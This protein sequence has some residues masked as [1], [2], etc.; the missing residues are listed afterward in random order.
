MMDITVHKNTA[1]TIAIQH[2]DASYGIFCFNNVGDLFVN[3]DWGFY[4]FAWRSFGNNFKEFL[5]SIN[6]DYMVGKFE[7][8]YQHV[9][10]KKMPA[11]YK[12]KLTV[13]ATE[14]INQLK[15]ENAG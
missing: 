15:L 12:K 7:Y 11:L 4:G 5:A 8:N 2:P 10:Q 13:L 1:E 9:A 3:S 6:P 14:F